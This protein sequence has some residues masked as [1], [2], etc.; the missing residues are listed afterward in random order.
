M[1]SS[2]ID[3]YEMR[4]SVANNQLTEFLFSAEM[5]IVPC[6]FIYDLF[7]DSITC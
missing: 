3:G 5:F 1:N 6:V 2:S 7:N 4:V